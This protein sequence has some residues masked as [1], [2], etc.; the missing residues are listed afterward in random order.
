MDIL[1]FPSILHDG[2]GRT[3]APPTA[4]TRVAPSGSPT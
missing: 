2:A 3:S 4:T 1:P